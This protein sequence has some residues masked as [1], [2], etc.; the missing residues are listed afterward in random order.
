MKLRYL[1]EKEFRQFIRN[2]FMP[3]LMLLMPVMLMLVFPYAATQ[4][5]TNVRLVFVD[6]DH[7]VESR[8]LI[9]KTTASG[10]FIAAD[11]CS[12]YAEALNAVQ[13][14]RADIVMEVAPHFGRNLRR[15][16]PSRV[17]VAANAVNGTKGQLGA[18]YLQSII[19]DFGSDIRV[20]Q[21][22]VSNAMALIG[23]AERYL[24]NPTLEYKYFMIPALFTMMLTLLAGFLPA[25]NIVSEKERGTIEQMNVSPV[26]RTE[27][28]LGKLIPYWVMG[29]LV[30]TLA[31]LLAWLTYDFA[32]R[33][34]LTAIYLLLVLFI[35]VVSG[36]GLLIS[37]F[38]DTMQQAM[39]VMFFFVLTFMLLSGMFT[40]V[41]SMP[42]WAQWIAAFN[43]LH[44]FVDAIR[45]IYLKGSTVT[46]VG[47]KMLSL[48]AFGLVIDVAAVM[49]YRKSS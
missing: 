30:A 17:M 23:L 13:T 24:F 36:F 41:T 14:G 47:D 38:S 18:A 26:S 34:P 33:G 22:N 2:P 42:T 49:S 20:E 5:V 43:P 39:F 3:R 27:F 9:E 46:E 11:Y 25:L 40:P 10:Y 32:P 7:S 16:E 6:N 44:Y 4:D 21:G 29:L 35:T 1:I 28:I 15:D 37:N 31:L 45:M 12:S 48:V 8:R 19:T